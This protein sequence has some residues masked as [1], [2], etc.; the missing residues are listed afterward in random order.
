M[1][2]GNGHS[3]RGATSQPSAELFCFKLLNMHMRYTKGVL[4]ASKNSMTVIFTFLQSLI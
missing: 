4:C 3:A 2:S 1:P